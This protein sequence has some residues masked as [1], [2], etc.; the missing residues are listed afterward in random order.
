M[1]AP[2]VSGSQVREALRKGDALGDATVRKVFIPDSVKAEGEDGERTYTFTI[3]TGIVD[4]ERDLIAIDGWQT[5]NFLK[6]G[7]PVLW[8][9][10]SF[11]LPIGRAPWVKVQDGALKARVEFAPASANPLAEQVRQLVDFGAIRAASVGFR[12]LPGRAAWNEERNGIDFLEQELLEFSIVPVPA[13]PEALLDAK[14][15]GI[16]TDLVRSWAEKCLY[17]L[18]PGLWLPKDA[19]ERALTFVCADDGEWSKARPKE[20]P[21]APVEYED[22][23]EDSRAAVCYEVT[24]ADIRAAVQDAVKE[25][26]EKAVRLARGRLD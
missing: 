7:G 17:S 14:A 11:G 23:H 24:E 8:A 9:H 16:D 1:P 15:A 2:V 10:N 26:A 3:S 5:E 6:A 25:I 19:A 12:P 4:R 21:P 13:N 18:E 22:D 20:S